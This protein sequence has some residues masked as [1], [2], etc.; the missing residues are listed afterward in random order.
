MTR[1]CFMVQ[2]LVSNGDSEVGGRRAGSPALRFEEAQ[3]EG[4]H[5][6]PDGGIS[7]H[8]DF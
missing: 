5:S 8:G 2:M 3:R 6:S 1:F 7:E 4:S